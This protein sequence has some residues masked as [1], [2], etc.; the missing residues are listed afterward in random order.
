MKEKRS[1]SPSLIDVFSSL[2]SFWAATWPFILLLALAG[3]FLGFFLFHKF[4]TVAHTVIGEADGKGGDSLVIT[5]GSLY[6]ANTFHISYFLKAFN[7]LYLAKTFYIPYLA[8]TSYISYVVKTSYILYL[9]KTSYISFLVKTSYISL[10]VK[11]LYSIPGKDILYSIPGKDILYSIFGQDI[12]QYISV[13]PLYIK[14]YVTP[15]RSTGV[16]LTNPP[17]LFPSTRKTVIQVHYDSGSQ[18]FHIQG[19]LLQQDFL[20]IT[21]HQLTRNIAKSLTL[22]CFFFK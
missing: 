21:D 3:V 2:L 20:K 6:L 17:S 18:L 10:V 22:N 16:G 5:T 9:I 12:L 13:F 4:I 8:K 14:Y 19:P 15:S 7:I 1:F 11:I